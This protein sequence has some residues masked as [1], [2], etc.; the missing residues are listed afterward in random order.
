MLKRTTLI[1]AL[2]ST[3]CFAQA[4]PKPNPADG[5]VTAGVYRNNYFGFEY[6]LPAGF[7]DHTAAMPRLTGGSFGLLHVTEPKQPARYAS[8]LTIF[9][10]DAN[11]W[12]VKNGAEYLDK[13][14]AQMQRSSDLVGKMTSFALGGHTFYRQDFSRRR[15]AARQT[16]VATVMKGYVLSAVL[17]AADATGIDALLAGWRRQIRA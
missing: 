1:A 17:T 8:S 7:T 11:E 12:K 3:L 10:D 9:A 5:A 4:G 13:F 16:V 15:V 6:K 14:G 2:L